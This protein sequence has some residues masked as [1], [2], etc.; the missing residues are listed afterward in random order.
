MYIDIGKHG[1][2]VHF[3][4]YGVGTTVMLMCSDSTFSHNFMKGGD[5]GIIASTV[6]RVRGNEHFQST[7]NQYN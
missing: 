5:K 4:A 2:L 6:P 1:V 7:C 3:V